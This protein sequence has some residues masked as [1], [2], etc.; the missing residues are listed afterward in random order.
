MTT[1]RGFVLGGTMIVDHVKIVKTY[2]Q[3]GTLAP[4]LRT[5]RG[6]GGC[7]VNNALNLRAVDPDLPIAVT[8]RVG[9]DEN[10][11]YILKTL[12]ANQ[13]DVSAV[14]VST[15][16]PTSQ[17]DVITV[18]GTGQRTFFHHQGANAEWGVEDIPFEQFAGFQIAQIGYILLLDGMDALDPDYGTVMARAFASFQQMG[19]KTAVDV[20]SEASDRFARLVTPT[21]RYVD[22][23][24]LN[25]FEAGQT[26]GMTLRDAT[27]RLRG[28]RLREVAEKLLLAGN[29]SLVVIHMPEGGYALSR[30]GEECKVPSFLLTEADIQGTVGA[31]DAFCSGVLYGLEQAWSLEDALQLG[32]TLAACSL[33]SPTA[34]GGILPLEDARR[35]MRPYPLRPLVF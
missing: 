10:G 8:G 18:R 6:L 29:S 3:E 35:K 4:I 16:A 7:P 2:P 32:S 14:V 34:T 1:R 15:T 9:D 27:G 30:A 21:L 5:S 12:Q 20:V 25:E 11:Q 33:F 17:T 19:L 22:Y 13:I 31:G 28:E 24:I 23:L 26:V